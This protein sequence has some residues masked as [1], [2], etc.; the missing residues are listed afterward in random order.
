MASNFAF[1]SFGLSQRVTVTAAATTMSFVVTQIGGGTMTLTAGNYL[2]GTAR[3]ANLGGANAYIQLGGNATTTVGTTSGMPLIGNTVEYIRI[4]GTP[5]MAH[6]SDG[7]TTL[8]L[9][10]G[11]GL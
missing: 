8:G 7:T 2:P 11:E 9:T 6:I 4:S 10:F 1:R 3:I 5:F